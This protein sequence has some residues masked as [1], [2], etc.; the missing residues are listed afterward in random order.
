MFSCLIFEFW[1]MYIYM[2]YWVR[3]YMCGCTW[4][5][6]WLEVVGVSGWVVAGLCHSR[7]EKRKGVEARHRRLDGATRPWKQRR[8]N[9]NVDDRLWEGGSIFPMNTSPSP[10]HLLFRINGYNQ[11]FFV[12]ISIYIYIY[13]YTFVLY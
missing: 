9:R 10:L 6:W 3:I 8:R 12:E 1:R 5:W 11:C 4:L 7:H 13:G 2:L